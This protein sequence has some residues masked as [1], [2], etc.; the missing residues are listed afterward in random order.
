MS[1]CPIPRSNFRDDIVGEVQEA[2]DQ[3]LV[4]FD[5]FG[6]EFVGCSGWLLDDEPAF[7]SDRDDDRVLDRLRLHQPENL[8]AEILLAV[9]PA[10]AAAGDLAGAHVHRLDARTVHV[11]LKERPRQR[12]QLDL[13]AGELDREIGLGL[14]EGSR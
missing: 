12:H 8:G 9:G 11:D 2:A 6:P 14:A 13:A 10:D 5:R 7:R 1:L 4:A 3:G